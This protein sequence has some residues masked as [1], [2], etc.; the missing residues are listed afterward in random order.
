MQLPTDKKTTKTQYSITIFVMRYCIITIL[1]ICANTGCLRAPDTRVITT[2]IAVYDDF[3]D[4]EP[5]I[6]QGTSASYT[7]VYDGKI[8]LAGGCNFPETPAADGGEKRYY[9]GIYAADI[10]DGNAEELKWKKVGELPEASAYGVSVSTPRGIIC[11]GGTGYN[12]AIKR[13]YIIS[14]TERSDT[15]K[16]EALPDMPYAMDN[17][18]GAYSNNTIY[19]SGGKTDGIPACTFITL[20]LDSLEAGWQVREPFPGRARLQPVGMIYKSGND[21]EYRILGGYSPPTETEGA[22][23]AGDGYKYSVAENKWTYMPYPAENQKEYMTFSGATA[24]QINDTA[25][26]VCGGVNKTIFATALDREQKLIRAAA[27][28]DTIQ[29]AALQQEKRQYMTSPPPWYKFNNK[30]LLYSTSAN[31]CREIA[32]TP[33]FALAGSSSAI[34]GDTLYF[35][36]GEIKPGIRTAQVVRVIIKH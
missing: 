32:E 21:T 5:G 31:T 14:R 29:I 2:E 4:G 26:A 23:V 18:C 10:T 3:P 11:A 13:A 33:C 28:G 27:A 16:T 7:G 17:M 22:V 35:L 36:G 1:T 20:N 12:G 19:I 15:I 9:K 34:S 6:S 8:Y 30:L 25:A 24:V